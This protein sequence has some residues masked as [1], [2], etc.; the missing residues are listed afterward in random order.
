[1]GTESL[2]M[3][4]ASSIFAPAVPLLM[5][6]FK[7]TNTELGAFVVSIY[8]LGFAVGPLL[9]APLSEMYGRLILYHTCNV[10]F[11]V[12]T[13]ACALSPTLN[14]L[15]VFRFIAGYAGSA[16]LTLGGGSIA[17]MVAQDRRG[18]AMTIFAMGPLLGPVIGPVAGGYLSEAK[19]WRWIFWL[20]TMLGGAI[21]ISAFFIMRE[22]YAPT[23]LEHRAKRLQRI[24][25]NFHLRSKLNSGLTPRQLFARSIIRP[26]K[27]LFL[28]PI[29]LALSVFMA[30]GYGYL[31]L[32]FTTFTSVFEEQY[33][34]NSGTVGLTYLG[35]GIG[36]MIGM[37]GVGVVSDTILKKKSGTGEMKP[38]YRLLP[39][40]YMSPLMCIGLFWYGW[41]AS[42][43]T[44]W[45]VPIIGTAIFGIGLFSAMSCITTYMVD[46]FT[47]YAAS[48][49]AANTVL[50]SIFGAVLPLVGQKMYDSLGL[51]WGN[52]LLAFVALAMCPIPLIFY[53]Y[54]ETIRKRWSLKL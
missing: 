33:G 36:S 2:I 19:G 46:A 18:V 3:P 54:G 4:L 10:L 52:S 49:L 30:L 14:A 38:E 51:A 11:V 39:M 34:F 15:I 29:V 22:T 20:L 44:F 17:D 5:A 28:S 53:R 50:R 42:A 41:S 23:I 16:P 12:F 13:A 37:A 47:A 40:I 8:V 48:A 27:M 26:L 24:T 21:T 25:S 31:Y 43:K 45:L 7:S 9:I 1:M 35:V 6:E 32:L